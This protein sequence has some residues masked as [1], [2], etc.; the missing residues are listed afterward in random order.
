M[1]MPRIARRKTKVAP[2]R[3]RMMRV[4]EEVGGLGSSV[5][6]GVWTVRLSELWPLSISL[7]WITAQD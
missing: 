4:L 6:G 3:P 2:T 5:R 7:T 1:L